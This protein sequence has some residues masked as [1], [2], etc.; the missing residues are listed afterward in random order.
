MKTGTSEE[1][2]G[3]GIKRPGWLM[4]PAPPGVKVWGAVPD[5]DTGHVNVYGPLDVLAVAIPP[6]IDRGEQGMELPDGAAV[7]TL[8]GWLLIGATAHDSECE[9]LEAAHELEDRIA[10]LADQID[11]A[12]GD[13]SETKH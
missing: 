2:I 6:V 8:R 11:Q 12:R 13:G 5:P 4:L 3:T 10:Q 7:L 9:A 1:N